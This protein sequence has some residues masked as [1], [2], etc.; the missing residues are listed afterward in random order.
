MSNKDDRLPPERMT[1]FRVRN[2]LILACCLAILFAAMGLAQLKHDIKGYAV[3]F[4][5]VALSQLSNVPQMW[6]DY[7]QVKQG[8]EFYMP[9]QAETAPLTPV[10]NTISVTVVLILSGFAGAASLV[11]VAA[12]ISFNTLVGWSAA[13]GIL[14]LLWLLIA[15]FWH[16]IFTEEPPF[17]PA[18]LPEQPEGVWPPA[19]RVAEDDNKD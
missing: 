7:R 19:P 2:Y 12:A 5:L 3:L 8:I 16:R 15:Y 13:A 11:I 10:P 9:A 1:L 4:C 18:L 17:K 6:K 14:L